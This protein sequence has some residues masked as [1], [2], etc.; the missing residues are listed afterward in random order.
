MEPKHDAPQRWSRWIDRF[1]NY[2]LATAIDKPPRQRAMLLHLIGEELYGISKTLKEN[3]PDHDKQETVYDT[4][5]VALTEYFSPKLNTEYEVFNFRE[6][7]QLPGEDLDT[8]YSRLKQLAVNCGF[9]NTD[10]E[11]KSQIIQKCSLSKLREEGLCKPGLTLSD[12]LKYGRTLERSKS[13]AKS[14]S[15]RK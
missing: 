13:Q 4:A 9:A 7:T 6:S 11:I 15:K 5:K 14:H 2:L 12:L 8:F 3:K 1:D 10:G